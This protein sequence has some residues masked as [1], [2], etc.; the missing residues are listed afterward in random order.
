MSSFAANNYIEYQP[1]SLNVIIS[2]PHGGT[3]RPSSIPNRDAGCFVNG[4]CIYT[5][6]AGQKDPIRCP[7][8]N[9]MDSYTKQLG[10]LIVKELTA[11]TNKRPYVIINHLHRMKVDVNT[12][13]ERGTF[14][15]PIAVE[16]WKAYHSFI[17][18][19]KREIGGP[20]LL[21]DIHGQ[22]HPE[23]WIELGYTL[24]ADQ[25]NNKTYCAKD[26]SINFLA[27]QTNGL[28]NYPSSRIQV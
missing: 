1:G 6:N 24:S 18:K 19:A 2:M 17:E 21:I 16:A 23:S 5:H 10:T 12:D 26:T 27:S 22:N 25:L 7:V 9:K 4:Q 3:L 28:L 13:L 20:G 8:R 11:L 15:V 14:G